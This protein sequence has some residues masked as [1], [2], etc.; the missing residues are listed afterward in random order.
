MT[1]DL[2]TIAGT[3]AGV[4]SLFV[5]VIQTFRYR[6]AKRLLEQ[7]RLRDQLSTWS[8]Y[9]LIVQAYEA[10]GEAREA[11]RNG[12]VPPAKALEKTAQSAALLN[13]MWLNTIEHAA[14]LEPVF[15]QATLDRWKALGRLD[16]EWRVSRAKKL[17]P[18]PSS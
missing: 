8:L 18:P 12:P 9:D 7:L 10:V 11:L 16:S 15:D 14:T 5:A 4:T 13:A 3:V 6:E 1:P 2:W 17:L